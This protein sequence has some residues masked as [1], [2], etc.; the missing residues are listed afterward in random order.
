MYVMEPPAY[1]SFSSNNELLFGIVDRIRQKKKKKI[2]QTTHIQN[3]LGYITQ[4]EFIEIFSI[5]K[6]NIET[7]PI[8]RFIIPGCGYFHNYK[9]G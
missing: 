6:C 4:E 9:E 7:L 8:F 1:F 3:S 5:A 2:K